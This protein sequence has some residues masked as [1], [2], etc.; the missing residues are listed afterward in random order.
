MVLIN[1]H[2]L[3]IFNELVNQIP[4]DVTN[5]HGI[6]NDIFNERFAQLTSKVTITNPDSGSSFE[7]MIYFWTWPWKLFLPFQAKEAFDEPND[8]MIIEIDIGA[9]YYNENFD[10]EDKMH[11]KVTK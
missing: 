2:F 7:V 1:R 11:F 3:N 10:I 6:L 5:R 8:Q 9:R 4:I